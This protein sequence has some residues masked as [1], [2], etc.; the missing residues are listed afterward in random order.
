M[1][2]TL[3]MILHADMRDY[4]VSHKNVYFMRYIN[5]E[6]NCLSKS[7]SSVVLKFTD[8]WKKKTKVL[9]GTIYVFVIQMFRM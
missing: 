4:Y 2:Y 9:K 5:T 1:Y 6:D 8:R 7:L 3:F